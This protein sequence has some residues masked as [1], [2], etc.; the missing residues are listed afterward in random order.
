[1]CPVRDDQGDL[2]KMH[3]AFARMLGRLVNLEDLRFQGRPERDLR[4]ALV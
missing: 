3:E 4:R 2:T 1:M